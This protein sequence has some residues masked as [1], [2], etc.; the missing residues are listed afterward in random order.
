MFYITCSRP[1]VMPTQPPNEKPTS[2]PAPKPD[3]M[4]HFRKNCAAVKLAALLIISM[5]DVAVAIGPW[6]WT[7][8]VTALVGGPPAAHAL[9][10]T[11]GP[12]P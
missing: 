2:K 5:G 4:A 7:A 12:R 8:L 1:T 9:A 3:R 6:G 10:R 11:L